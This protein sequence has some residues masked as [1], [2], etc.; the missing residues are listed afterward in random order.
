MRTDGSWP[1]QPG[2]PVGVQPGAAH[3][4]SA[5]SSPRVVSS[6]TSRG[7]VGATHD[8]GA[9]QQARARVAQPP[10]EHAAHG[11]VVDDAGLGHV[12]RGDGRDV[13]LVLAGLRPR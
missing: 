6:T 1:E 11:A 13:R 9:R 5:P 4:A 12:Q 3:H 2:D 8:L 7:A 10:H